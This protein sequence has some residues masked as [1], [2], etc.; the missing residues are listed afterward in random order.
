MMHISDAELALFKDWKPGEPITIDQTSIGLL[1]LEAIESRAALRA[2]DKLDDFH[3]NCQ[4]CDGCEQ[5]EA[6]EKCWPYADDAR[7]KMRAIIEKIDGY[8]PEP[9]LGA[10]RDVFDAGGEQ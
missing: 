3:A 8:V 4:N 9:T 7:L 10:Y 6:C 1:I 5:P 2:Y